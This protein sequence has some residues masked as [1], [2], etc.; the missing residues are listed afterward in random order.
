MY[1]L[2]PAREVVLIIKADSRRRNEFDASFHA[3]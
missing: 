2:T 3:P 1:G